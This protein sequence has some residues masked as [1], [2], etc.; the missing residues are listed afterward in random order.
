MADLFIEDIYIGNIE[1]TSNGWEIPR[2]ETYSYDGNKDFIVY[3]IK[4]EMYETDDVYAIFYS[5]TTKSTYVLDT[6][7]KE[8]MNPKKET[9][10]LKK[11]LENELDYT[12][13]NVD[14]W[15]ER[16]DLFEW[17]VKLKEYITNL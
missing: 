17:K 4:M 10:E 2:V 12:T 1:H 3:L 15:K 9:I 5:P 6:A 16:A 13:Y 14:R 11:Y 8:N 7:D